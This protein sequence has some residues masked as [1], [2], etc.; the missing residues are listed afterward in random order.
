MTS[1]TQFFEFDSKFW[2]ELP[3][4]GPWTSI[5]HCLENGAERAPLENA[6][7]NC[8]LCCFF[9]GCSL[10]TTGIDWFLLRSIHYHVKG[11]KGHLH[12][13]RIFLLLLMLLVVRFVGN[14]FQNHLLCTVHVWKEMMVIKSQ[15][16]WFKRVV[17]FD[18]ASNWASWDWSYQSFLPKDHPY[19]DCVCRSWNQLFFLG[20]IMNSSTD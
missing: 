14:Y 15:A 13:F 19:F 2:K 6:F 8:M 16:T 3:K 10:E 20:I 9:C 18:W 12:K 7:L 4:I 17:L 5:C 11:E 1:L